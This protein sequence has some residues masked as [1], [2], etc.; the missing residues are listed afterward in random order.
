[1]PVR[2]QI[3]GTLDEAREQ[4]ALGQREVLHV[5]VEVCA[6]G[7]AE[8]ADAERASLTQ[9][10]QVGIHLKDALLGELLFQLNGNENFGELALHGFFRSEEKTARKLHGQGRAALSAMAVQDVGGGGLHQAEIIDAAV[11]KEAAIFDGD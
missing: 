6:G 10:N 8:S 1:M 11:L 3:A 2:R 4:G 5:F 7:L 9:R